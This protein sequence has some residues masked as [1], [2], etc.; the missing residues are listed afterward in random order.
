MTVI[1]FIAFTHALIAFAVVRRV[2]RIR[3]WSARQ[4]SFAAFSCWCIPLF[5]SIAVIAATFGSGTDDPNLPH[6]VDQLQQYE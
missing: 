4:R 6:A 3:Y 2:R 1:L 5:G